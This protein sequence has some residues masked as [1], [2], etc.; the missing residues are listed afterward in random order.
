MAEHDLFLGGGRTYTVPSSMFPSQDVEPDCPM[1]A[2]NRRGDI[3]FSLT[4]T[5]QWKCSREID[6][7]SDKMGSDALAQY[8]KCNG[9]PAQDDI[10]NIVI[11]PRWSSMSEVWVNV[12]EAVPGLEYEIKV[13]GNAA[14]LGGTVDA[15][16]PV[17]VGTV[18]ASVEGSQL[19]VLDDKL[20]FDQNDMLQV[21]ITA[22][23]ET[24]FECS[25]VMISPV[26]RE[27]CRGQN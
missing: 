18:D 22:M 9:L 12:D 15:P 14:S 6:D 1:E 4:R 23:P 8:I 27:Y 5:L 13:R 26:V 7:C 21:C 10:L 19:I 25:C 2:D 16:A 3:D 17:V 11:L 20:Y 24:G